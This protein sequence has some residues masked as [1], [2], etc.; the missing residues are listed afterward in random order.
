MKKLF[1]LA[2]LLFSTLL[3]Q[4]YAASTLDDIVQRG[5]L[6][7]GVDAGYVPFAMQN[8]NGDIVGF[9]I[10]LA[11]T[12]AKAMGVKLT[13]VN[14]AW[15]GIIPAL[16]TNKI[17]LIMDGMTITS[18]RN[19]QVNF[20]QP[21]MVIGQSLL[22]RPD[23][24]DKIH[25][26]KDLNEGK[27]KIA[28]KL[29]ATS[30]YAAKRYLPNAELRLFDTEA[31]AVLEVINGNA[32]AFVYDLPYNA[33]YV[34]QNKG[35]LVHLDQPFTYEPLGIALRRGDVDTLNFLDNFLSQIKGDGSFDR[36]YQKWFESDSW[37][38]QVQ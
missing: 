16:L 4:A 34:Q 30:E 11:R 7:I 15:D 23:L 10:D 14:T 36:L 25:S 28:T 35:K 24:A 8:K 37:L 32:D 18:E 31:E 6:R 1:L 26:Y 38:K 5:E 27:Y 21:Y 29:G 22:L 13:V 20:T 3:S 2:S 17:D 33:I 19:L 12:M 9:D